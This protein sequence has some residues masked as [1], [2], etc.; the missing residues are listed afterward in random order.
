MNTAT[1]KWVDGYQFVGKA[2]SGH[3]VVMDAGSDIGGADSGVRPG[4]LPLIG[5]GGCTGVD[6]ILI[7]SKMREPIDT[8]E[9]QVRG[10]RVD[11]DP[12]IFKEIWVKYIIRG[13]IREKA[14]QRAVR[15]SADKYCSVGAIMKASATMHYEY[16]IIYPSGETK[17]GTIGD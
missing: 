2:D 7:L 6:V 8:F 14:V 12:S 11:E 3:A 4:E 17:T 9:I 1:I 5:L 15:L 10:E 16:E 13:D